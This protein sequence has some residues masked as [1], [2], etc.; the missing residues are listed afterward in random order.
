M[1]A[2]ICGGWEEVGSLSWEGVVNLS[3]VAL[4]EFRIVDL[5]PGARVPRHSDFR[6]GVITGR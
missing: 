5:N 1:S 3:G 2:E 4:S 6:S